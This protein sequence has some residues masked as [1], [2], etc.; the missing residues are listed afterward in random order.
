MRLPQVV[1][2][3]AVI[4]LLAVG[5]AWLVNLDPPG[6]SPVGPAAPVALDPATSSGESLSIEAPTQPVAGEGEPV[7]GER[8][9]V[10]AGGAT[11]LDGEAGAGESPDLTGRVVGSF[12]QPVS[13][14]RVFAAPAGLVAAIDILGDDSPWGFRRSSTESGPDGRFELSVVGRGGQ[15]QLAVRAAG[16]APLRIQRSGTRPPPF[17]LGDLVLE[18]SVFLSGHVLDSV[19]RGVA[20]AELHVASAE[21]AGVVIIMQGSTGTLVGTTDSG[22]GFQLDELGAGR[23]AIDVRHPDYPSARFEGVTEAPGE[24]RGGIVV[25]LEPGAAISGRV[26]GILPGEHEAY[27]VHAG[28]VGSGGIAFG[29]GASPQAGHLASIE[30]D[31][32]FLMRGL[33]A[34]REVELKILESESVAPF[35][36]ACSDT[37][38]AAGGDSG[39]VLELEHGL[40]LAFRVVEAG[41]ETALTDFDVEVGAPWPE[42]VRDA[43]GKR[44]SHHPGGTFRHTGLELQSGIDSV[45]VRV[46]SELHLPWE[47]TVPLPEGWEIELGTIR[48][49]PAPLIRVLVVDAETGGAVSGARVTLTAGGQAEGGEGLFGGAGAFFNGRET[50]R[51]RTDDGGRVALAA[52]SDGPCLLKA[53]HKSYADHPGE[54]VG[55]QTGGAEHVLRLS[56]GGRVE[57]L[58]VEADGQPRE[59]ARVRHRGP[60]SARAAPGTGGDGMRTCDEDGRVVYR[61]LTVG[62][63]RFRLAADGRGGVGGFMGNATIMIGEPAGGDDEE[64][65]EEVTVIDGA[66]LELTLVSE[67]RGTLAGRVTEDGR[68][69]SGARVSLAPAAQGDADPHQQALA[70][71]GGGGPHTKTDPAGRYELEE[72]TVGD[73]L[74]LVSHPTRTMVSEFEVQ[75]AAAAGRFDVDLD[76]AVIEGRVSDGEG[77]PLAGA[78]VEVIRSTPSGGEARGRTRVLSMSSSGRQMTIGAGEGDATATTDPQGRYRLRGVASGLELE[79]KASIAGRQSARSEPLNLAADETRSRVDLVLP[80]AGSIRLSVVDAGGRPASF[81][82]TEATFA[83]EEELEVADVSQFIQAGGSAVLGGLRPGPWEVTA[84]SI[85]FG[86]P[87]AQAPPESEPRRVEVREGEVAE[88]EVRLP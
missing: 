37:V 22:G 52:V 60:S 19:G 77:N 9:P 47:Q 16:F 4:G 54:D 85:G 40:A 23:Y 78:R 49:V 65:W 53:T 44:L 74:L 36:R 66:T 43:D 82:M 51:G 67:P 57:I 30:P 5:L 29:L 2:L 72:I 32:S 69:L 31:G 7:A 13:G 12:G 76:L 14:A 83:G 10:A 35:G 71:L 38:V 68:P 11:E 62:V 46:R 6:A 73:Y 33:H 27:V 79:V 48:L 55:P 17:E 80:G 88:V 61:K 81:C 20:D 41:S 86:N 50:R 45:T 39:V 21:G 18:P 15:V 8:S 84:R 64:G 56:R 59:G 24:V 70:L 1:A 63:H 87:G 28:A 58:V 42:A 26:L 34:E 3:F 75:V 25:T